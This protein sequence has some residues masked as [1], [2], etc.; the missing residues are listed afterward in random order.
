LQVSLDVFRPGS[1]DRNTLFIEISQEMAGYAHILAHG[2]RPVPFR[3]QMTS[4]FRKPRIVI[5]TQ[6]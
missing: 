1:G 6:V 2:P 4:Q 3:V 5:K